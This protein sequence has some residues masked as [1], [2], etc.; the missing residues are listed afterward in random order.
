MK[1]APTIKIVSP[2]RESKA[3]LAVEDSEIISGSDFAAL[4]DRFNMKGAVR[5]YRELGN[6]SVYLGHDG[7][8]FVPQVVK[9]SDGVYCLIFIA[10]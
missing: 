1:D 9:D 4:L 10:K 2:E 6:R 8:K 3:T 7:D 5:H